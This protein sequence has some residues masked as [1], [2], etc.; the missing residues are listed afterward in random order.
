MNRLHLPKSYPV[1]NSYVSNLVSH[2]KFCLF[3]C[4]K[5]FQ[6]PFHHKVHCSEMLVGKNETNTN[7]K[8]KQRKAAEKHY[9]LSYPLCGCLIIRTAAILL[10]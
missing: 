7:E 8:G 4:F 2:Y 9:L 6:L 5:F 10:L 3:V 1:A